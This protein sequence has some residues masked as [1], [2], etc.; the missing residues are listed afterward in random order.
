MVTAVS[1]L[2]LLLLLLSLLRVL[3]RRCARWGVV[4][5]WEAGGPGR[6]RSW[7]EFMG[8]TGTGLGSTQKIAR[9]IAGEAGCFR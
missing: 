2:L 6:E 8:S 9:G 5:W 1:V 7:E 3:R 4:P